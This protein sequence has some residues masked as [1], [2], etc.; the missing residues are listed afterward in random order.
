M[1]NKQGGHNKQGDRRFLLNFINGGGRGVGVGVKINGG[2]VG[3][4][5]KTLLKS[6]MNKKRDINV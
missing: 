1:P 2:G 3:I 4:L 6:V 5:K